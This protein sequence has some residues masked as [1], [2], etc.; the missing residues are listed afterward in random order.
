MGLT[1]AQRIIEEHMGEITIDSRLGRGTVIT[2]H[3]VRERRRLIRTTRLEL[4]PGNDTIIEQFLDA[5][6]RADNTLPKTGAG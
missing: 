6:T 5:P 1:F 3:L 2:F 4:Q